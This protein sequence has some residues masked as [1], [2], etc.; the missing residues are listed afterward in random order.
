MTTD[1]L[2]VFHRQ[3]NCTFGAEEYLVRDNGAVLRRSR[4][5]KRKR[6]LDETWT[7]G[8]P[9]AH[10]GY[11]KVSKD[12][13]H[14]VVATAFHG[15]QP[16]K[17]HVVDHIDTNRRNNRPENLRW[18]TRLENLLLN[19]ITARRVEYHYGSIEAFLADP[20]RP[21]NGALEREFEWMRTVTEAEATYSL[22]RL[23]EWS[24]SGGPSRGGKLGEWI[25]RTRSG[26]T[27]GAS[28]P[29]IESKTPGALQRDWRVPAE[30][31]CSPRV[32]AAGSLEDYY[33]S[34]A[35]G[36]VFVQT[37]FGRTTVVQVAL[38]SDGA[39]MF[40]LG[41]SAEG[42]LKPWSLVR[43]TLE[44]GKFVHQSLGTFFSREGGEKRFTLSQG[45][46]WEGGDS[47][48]DYS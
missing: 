44:G 19:P 29:L 41:E 13:V 25:Y 10:S 16:S 30:F 8:N 40:V 31:P 3:V 2:G 4:D 6:P 9:C 18:V 34:L 22:R 23:L 14:R 39:E 43:V 47:I 20:S 32:G 17:G 24:K 15:P 7:F 5:G 33:K 42:S 1:D 46:P 26:P 28:E 11:M 21:I 36:A 45:L 37:R 38:A 27:Q 48:D 12:V 35:E